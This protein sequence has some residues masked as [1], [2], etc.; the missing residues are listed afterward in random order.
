M[1]AGHEGALVIEGGQG[2]A[3]AARSRAE[4]FATL[5]DR[6]LDASYRLASLILGN[7]AEA[8]DAVHDALVQAW[9]RWDGLRDPGRFEAWFGRIVTNACRDRVRR[10]R[11]APVAVSEPPERPGPDEMAGVPDRELL[12]QALRSLDVD[13]RI[14][15]VL[16]YFD[17][18]TV[19]EIAIRIGDRPGTVKSRLHYALRELRA[20]LEAADR[21]HGEATR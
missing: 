5:T 2:E 4:A 18:L 6:G 13:H 9:R 3:R 16:R 19:D 17:D 12:R 10:R 14:V 8:E 11:L 15:I 21:R 7:P 20:V 1:R